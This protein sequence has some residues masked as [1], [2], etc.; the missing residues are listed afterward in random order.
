M[1]V[2]VCLCQLIKVVNK[3]LLLPSAS[4]ILKP[5]NANIN[6]VGYLSMPKQWV[7]LRRQFFFVFCLILTM[8]KTDGVDPGSTPGLRHSSCFIRGAARHTERS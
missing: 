1:I 8:A 5:P 7:D 6:P 2:F 3:S 4:V